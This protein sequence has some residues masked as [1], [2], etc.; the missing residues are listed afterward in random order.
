MPDCSRRPQ[1]SCF[2]TIPGPSRKLTTHLFTHPSVQPMESL[3]QATGF[4]IGIVQ[5]G[6]TEK[7][8][9]TVIPEAQIVFFESNASLYR[10]AQK[11]TIKAFVSTRIALFYFLRENRL[12]NIFGFNPQKPLFTQTY[13]TA[14]AKGK[15]DLIAAVDRGLGRIDADARRSLEDKWIV[16]GRQNDSG[17]TGLP[18]ERSRAALPVRLWK[19]SGFKTKATGPRLISMRTA[20]LKAIPIDYIRLL[21]EKT[22][23]A[24]DFVSGATW[25][26]DLAMMKAG[27]L[28]VMLNIARTPERQN[29]LAFTPGYVEMIQMLYTRNDFP[30]VAGIEDLFGKRFAVPR[31]VYIAEALQAYPQIEVLDVRVTRPSRSW[32]FPPVRRMRCSI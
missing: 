20:S 18:A 25:E 11:G 4:V 24:V 12:A 8:V 16:S 13:Y 10:A 26:D 23:L 2:W 9:R 1:E 14:T 6:Y 30:E 32:R 19:R 28:D 5:G 31:G 22:G 17:R 3:E 27:T 15:Q 29:Y 7:M 21:A